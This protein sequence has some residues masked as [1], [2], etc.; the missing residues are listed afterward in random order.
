MAIE[1]VE[2]VHDL[3]AQSVPSCQ[4]A[5][6]FHH[7]VIELSTELSIKHLSLIREMTV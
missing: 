5:I 6:N 3:D 7:K 1:L 2:F 4:L